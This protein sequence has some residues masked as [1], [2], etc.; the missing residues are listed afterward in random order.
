[1]PKG[2][3]SEHDPSRRADAA[4]HAGRRQQQLVDDIRSHPQM[5]IGSGSPVDRYFS[6]DALKDQFNSVD[7]A[8][9]VHNGFPEH[10]LP[11]STEYPSASGR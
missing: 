7:H 2:S 11:S 10:Q 6:D 1:M 9:A 8:L 5:G 3:Y 4:S